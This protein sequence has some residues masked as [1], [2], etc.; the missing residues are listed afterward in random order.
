MPVEFSLGSFEAVGDRVYVAVAQ[1]ASVNIGLVVGST[2]ALVVDTG[3]SPAQGRAILAAARAVAGDVP[4][5][6][7]AVT[8]HHWD[9]LFG[10]AGFEGVASVGHAG[11]GDDVAANLRLDDELADLGLAR[12]DVELPARGFALAASVDLGDCHAELVHF[13]R[14]HTASDCVVI[15]P[16]RD[17]VFAG[18]LLE[19]PHPSVEA[20]SFLKEW[21]KTLDGTLGTL[22]ARTVVVPGHGAPLDRMAAFMQRAELHWLDQRIEGLYTRAVPLAEAYA[23]AEDWPWDEASVRELLPHA[24]ARLAASGVRQQRSRSLPLRPL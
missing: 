11:L 16:E 9:H 13:G 2:G 1:P 7:V 24:Y 10:L 8:H 14:G 21:P 20:G 6:H 4:V 23:A 5:T 12:S 3:S 18:D 19:T 15:V 22:R 17:V